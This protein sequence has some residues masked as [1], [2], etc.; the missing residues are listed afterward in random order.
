MKLARV[1]A[2]A[3]AALV[4]AT[5]A[6]HAG[7]V[8]G[9]IGALVGSLAGGGFF[10]ALIGILINVGISL[11][12]RAL[13]KKDT[14]DQQPIGVSG[15][16]QVGGDNPISFIMGQYATPGSL[17][18][19][20]TW[21]GDNQTPNAFLVQVISLTDMP[22][23]AL[24]GVFVDGESVT[25][26]SAD[27]T[28]VGSPVQEYRVDGQDFLWVKFHDG[29]QTVADSYLTSK[30]ASVTG[31]DWTT[32]M[33][34]RGV[35]YAI[36]TA[37]VNREL[38]PNGIPQFKFVVNGMKLYD[39]RK[40]STNG[41]SGAHRW[42]DPTTWE[43]SIN[44]ILMIY[45]LFRGV[46]YGSQWVYGM[47]DLAQLRLPAASWIAAANVC[48]QN[49]AITG[50]T[51]KRYR[52]GIEIQVNRQVLDVVEELC[53]ACNCRI[54]DIGG[55]YKP[56]VDV[57]GSGVYAFTDEDIVITEG[58][59][60]EPFPGLESTYNA[61]HASYPEPREAWE[62]KD[63]PPR[64]FTPLEATDD[65]RRLIADIAL[66]TV[67]YP[68]QVQR[69]M[70]ALIQNERRFRKHLLP[71]P[72]E[73][74]LLEPNDIVEWTSTVNGYDSKLFIVDAID[75]AVTYMQNVALREVDPTDYDWST[76]FELPDSVGYL[77]PVRP[78]PQAIVDWF[79]EGVT[80]TGSTGKQRAGIH[81]EWDGNQDDVQAVLFQV[82]MRDTQAVVLRN[83]STDDVAAGAVDISANIFSSTDYQVRGRYKPFSGRATLWSDWI[84]VT[85]PATP[86]TDIIA[87]LE[88]LN[89]DIINYLKERNDDFDDR[90]AKVDTYLRNMV[91][92]SSNDVLD[93]RI[94]VKNLG[95]LTASFR[96]EVAVRVTADEAFVAYQTET[97]ATLDDLAAGIA[98]NTS[99]FNELTSQVTTLGN[100][101]TAQST[102]NNQV[103][104]YLN[105]LQAQVTAAG[106]A[107]NTLVGRVT[108]N[109]Q[110]VTNLQQNIAGVNATIGNLSA[111]VIGQA[112]SVTALTAQVNSFQGQITAVAD[113]TTT[114]E[115]RTSRGT[116]KGL[117]AIT[118][119]SG[120]SGVLVRLQFGA[121]VTE[122]GN[123]F[124]S[125][126]YLDVTATGSQWVF[127][128]TRFIITNQSG[129]FLPFVFEG[130]VLKLAGAQIGKLEFD[131]LVSTNG[132]L[133]LRGYG[134]FADITLTN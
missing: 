127:D 99:G 122:D 75:G 29:S 60:Y 72:P 120:P 3:I 1:T 4:I 66:P 55:L 86:Y 44:P 53:K 43:Y 12:E 102:L 2:A 50:G 52:A 35:A 107:F 87:G 36:V 103:Q 134:N 111:Q 38:F 121:R 63:A 91:A 113:R 25:L 126:A 89:E 47:Q 83:G 130:G 61:V 59:Q 69:L 45:T 21:G 22:A 97:S 73:A 31:R 117:F 62:S 54:A 109:E 100:T 94:I 132:K 17:E 93:R 114:V 131:Q 112:S 51:E 56:T 118:S 57:A 37:R 64:F 46:Y 19:A 77:G 14:G 133:I 70:Y 30:F 11:L 80:I 79:A 8:I 28:S 71:L 58:Q 115:A 23:A 26:I 67:P 123:T 18:Y 49:V 7:P 104:S 78:A 129:K 95:K 24:A 116:A 82:R 42:S 81:L 98:A 9:A 27:A 16:L 20:N 101:V 65:N 32:D 33:I 74:W 5:G 119:Q 88:E 41:G 90:F 10:N 125:G 128:A 106:A 6:A 92:L 85:T 15:S 124:N 40:D 105:S 39:I 76:D 110:G 96:Q 34:G 108:L 68:R 13:K 84:N 48:D